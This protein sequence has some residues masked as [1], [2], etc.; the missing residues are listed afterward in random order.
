M[1][2]GPCHRKGARGSGQVIVAHLTV[3]RIAADAEFG[4]GPLDV[5]LVE[6]QGFGDEFAFDFVEG[7][8]LSRGARLGSRRFGAWVAGDGDR[9]E[10]VV[11]GANDGPL[12]G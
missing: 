6:G 1:P 5:A 4:G 11:A 10:A 7:A 2:P 3:Q 9:E 8:D 12:D